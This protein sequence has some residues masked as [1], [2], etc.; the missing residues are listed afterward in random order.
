M[1]LWVK[2]AFDERWWLMAAYWDSEIPERS[3]MTSEVQRRDRDVEVNLPVS[4][5]LK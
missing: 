3:A 2:D 4:G 1:T 5:E